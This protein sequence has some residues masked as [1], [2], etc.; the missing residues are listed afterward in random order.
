MLSKVYGC[1]IKGISGHCVEVETFISNGI[2]NFE[3]VGQVDTSVK[4]ARERVKAAIKNSGFDYPIRKIVVNL[5]P[6]LL[7]KEGT[8]FDLPIA[9]GILIAS[10]QIK[11]INIKDSIFIGELSLDGSV[12][13]VCGVVSMIIA[14]RAKG[15]NKAFVPE[16]N[17]S[18][19]SIVEGIQVVGVRNLFE[20]GE[21][22]KGH[23]LPMPTIIEKAFE[24]EEISDFSDVKGH[25]EA[26]R[27]LE[28]AA[29]GGHSI[30]LLGS[31]GSGKT[32]LAR[33]FA[34]I[35]P[36]MNYEEAIETTQIHSI[37]GKSV[38]HGLLRNRPFRAPH[39][40]ATVAALAG[41]GQYPRPGEITLAH[42]GVLF[43]DEL[44]EFR[45]EALEALRQPLEDGYITVS[46]LNSTEV[47]PSNVMLVCAAN[48]CKC[49]YL[50]E[51]G[52]CKCSRTQR[53]E[54]F[55][56]LS[57]ALLN[58]IDMNIQVASVSYQQ[59]ES[60]EKTE[61]SMII[62]KR[63]EKTRE[64]QAQ[65]YRD[66]SFSSNSWI[67]AYYLKAFIVREIF[68]DGSIQGQLGLPEQ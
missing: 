43:L 14:A 38:V 20:V 16:G 26:K 25:Y 28:I 53:T 36:S 21:Y 4:E 13:S 66:E 42:N 22:L 39:H 7:R 10:E 63:V 50:F 29:S 37:S 46:R 17:F 18:E 3:I 34:G 64:V 35:L 9:I 40:S 48:P 33:R 68:L 27:A 59:L 23:P 47:F 12:K 56:K 67:Q 55:G 11:M 24:N 49:G 58:R 44:P 31:P 54:Y 15:A 52:K 8:G 30:L 51:D 57:G 65:R 60:K 62:K 61:K 2:P 1:G 41:G 6:A 45:S 19:A 32:M 5:S